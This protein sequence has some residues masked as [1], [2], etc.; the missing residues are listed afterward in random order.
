MKKTITYLLF[1]FHFFVFP[2]SVFSQPLQFWEKIT[3]PQVNYKLTEEN[4]IL[5]REE[6]FDTP[7]I[8][9]S[10]WQYY[11]PWGR[12]LTTNKELQCYTDS[13]NFQ[14][15]DNGILKIIARKE[16][17]ESTV[18][19]YYRP[20]TL[21]GDSL[22]NFRSFTHTSAML[23]SKTKFQY[24]KFELRCKI[25]ETLGSWLGFW[26]FGSCAQE[27]DIVEFW[28]DKDNPQNSVFQPHVTFHY[29]HE[30]NP[31][32]HKTFGKKPEIPPTDFSA[33]FHTFA[34]FWN[35]QVVRWYIDDIVVYEVYRWKTVFG[36]IPIILSE[37]VHKKKVLENILFPKNEMALI[38]NLAVNKTLVNYEEILEIDYIRIYGFKGM[39]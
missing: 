21:L 7:K 25:P 20:T 38:V 28:N 17:Y 6:N 35:D 9:T 34:V 24:G 8:D 1:C 22:P 13:G 11:Y 5:L 30:C 32:Q 10:F 19:D 39:K 18:V 14:F 12:T 31:Q 3:E 29:N 15:T 2:Q 16:F 36:K 27:I 37:K 23:Y 26:L 4:L 33:D